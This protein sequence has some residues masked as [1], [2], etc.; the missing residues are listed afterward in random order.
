MV[1]SSCSINLLK[2]LTRLRKIFCL[3]LDYPF[4]YKKKKKDIT[5]DQPDGRDAWGE[6]RKV[7]HTGAFVPLVFGNVTSLEAL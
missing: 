7:T 2:R 3:L 4:S 5:P 6:V 1:L